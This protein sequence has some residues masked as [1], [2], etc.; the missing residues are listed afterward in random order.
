M[1]SRKRAQ[2]FFS[3]RSLNPKEFEIGHLSDDLAK[4]YARDL[5][6]I[7]YV[8]ESEILSLNDVSRYTAIVECTSGKAC[9][10]FFDLPR[11]PEIKADG[12]ARRE[13]TPQ[14]PY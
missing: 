2:T 4:L 14:V 8:E 12:N 3:S 5:F 11:T 13:F 1:S 10:V 7:G 6:L 9:G